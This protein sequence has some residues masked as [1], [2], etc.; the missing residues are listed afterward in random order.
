[1]IHD[2]RRSK[3]MSQQ[4][5]QDVRGQ[6][7]VAVS[8]NTQLKMVDVLTLLKIPKSERPDFWIRVAKILVQHQRPSGSS[9]TKSIWS[10]TCRIGTGAHL[11]IKS[12]VYSY[13]Y[14]W[15]P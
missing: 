6:V 3:W 12:V 7:A 15:M 9:R 14:T 5:R 2:G 1:M 13:L 4:G 11:C 8:A 10:P